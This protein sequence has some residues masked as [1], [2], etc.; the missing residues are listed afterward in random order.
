MKRG[1]FPTK[2]RP[3]LPRPLKFPIPLVSP[4]PPPHV[5]FRSKENFPLGSKF[6]YLF[7]YLLLLIFILSVAFAYKSVGGFI[8]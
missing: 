3:V 2:P 5:P 8:S 6:I 7:I 1:N 4:N